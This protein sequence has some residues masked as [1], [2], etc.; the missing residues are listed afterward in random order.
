MFVEIPFF[1]IQ[2]S[3]DMFNAIREYLLQINLANNYKYDV[4]FRRRSKIVLGNNT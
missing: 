3:L 1:L 4:N 2:L